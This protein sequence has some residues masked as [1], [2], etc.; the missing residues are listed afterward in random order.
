MM[1]CTHPFGKIEEDAGEERSL[2]EAKNKPGGN[3][4]P[5]GLDLTS[6]ERHQA[7]DDDL[8]DTPRLALSKALGECYKT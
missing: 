3:D 1:A 7:P 2:D 5:R 6:E 8:R 4:L